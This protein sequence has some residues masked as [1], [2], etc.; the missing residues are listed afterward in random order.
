MPLTSSLRSRL[1]LLSMI[2]VVPAAALMLLTQSSERNRARARTLESNLRLT[3]LAATQQAA[4]FDAAHDLL[5]TL[6]HF[7]SVRAADPGACNALLPGIVEDHVGYSW[8]TVITAN[9]FPFCSSAPMGDQPLRDR[10]WFQR[11]V[12]TR[13]T[14]VGDYQLGRV[15]GLPTIVVAQPLLSPSGNVERLIIAAIDLG[16]LTALVAANEPPSGATLTVFDRNLVIVA[17]TPD[18]ARWVGH[19][20][21]DT[22]T[23]R[24][25]IASGQTDMSESM[26]VDGRPRL[27]VTVPVEASF[28]TG[29]YVGMGIERSA[30]FAES[31]RFLYRSVRGLLLIALL[32]GAMAWIG[33]EALVLRP[34]HA[35]IAVTNRLAAGDLGVR[36][37][38]RS[39][40]REMGQLGEAFDSMAGTLEAR[41]MERDAAEQKLAAA[42]D[43]AEKAN[44]A[45]SEFLANMSHEIRTP[46]NGII[47]M[48]DLALQTD[49]TPEQ[50]ECME[51]VKLSADSLIT[52]I[53]DILDFSKMEAGRVELEAID[54]QLREGLESI[55][56]TMALRAN[57]KGLKL[58]CV[59]A[60]EVPDRLHGDSGRLRQIIVN[61]VGNAIKFT[62]S[63]EVAVKVE[64]DDTAQL[65]HF[66]VSDTG[67]GIPPDKQRSIFDPFSQADTSTTRQYGGTGLGLTISM[68]LVELMG[69]RI[70]VESQIG[71]GTQ[72]HFTAR[73]VPEVGQKPG[74]S[75]ELARD[76]RVPLVL[77]V[78][79]LRAATG[80]SL[81]ARG[82]PQ[83]C[84]KLLVAEDN[85][86]NQLLMTRLLEKRGHHV[87]LAANGREA[88][89]AIARDRYDLV[90]M[91]MQMPEMDGL[92]ATAAIR[93]NEK[94]HGTRLTV[95]A[96]TAHAMKGDRE[97]CLAAG[98]DDYLSKPIG[99]Q[100]LDDVLRRYGRGWRAAEPAARSA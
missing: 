35:F 43:V 66:S 75:P 40:V 19:Q 28:P 100:E 76:A 77:D 88:I 1:L 36:A 98:M 26:G 51:T 70:W 2:A 96:L 13:T 12:Q 45:K 7:P 84:L 73:L 3:R 39:G 89:E 16:R 21:P 20:V 50:R 24:R 48:T 9:G 56:R 74:T 60:P 17:R 91:D 23:T 31:D 47:G 82:E 86:V 42:T 27:Y 32:A 15:S 81:P 22:I 33:S 87:A 37:R 49:L 38:I 10:A 55:L 69:G 30:A 67:I 52:V 14:S 78:T 97:R 68:R 41:Q 53:N 64:A 85:S 25:L 90:F 6:A 79:T 80:P 4:V 61:L 18:S 92:E 94:G 65:L 58:L 63:G 72:F 57:E 44:R 34:I 83:V 11:A 54:F 46:M 8:L 99:V 29:L 62:A 71:R 59:V 5:V 93:A 95:I